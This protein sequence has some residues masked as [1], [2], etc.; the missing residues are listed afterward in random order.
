V[1][2]KFNFQTV[3]V[4]NTATVILLLKFCLSW[5][6]IAIKIHFDINRLCM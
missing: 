5:K 3:K 6:D 1:V 4:N 2:L